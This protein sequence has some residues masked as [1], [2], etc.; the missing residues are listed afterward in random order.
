MRRQLLT[1]AAIVCVGIFGFAVSRIARSQPVNV[2]NPQE[3]VKAIRRGGLREVAKVKG[4]YISTVRSSGWI[5][6]DVDSLTKNSSAVIV[7]ESGASASELSSNGE[8]ITTQYQVKIREV[9][10]GDVIE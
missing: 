8:S 9:L 3:E 2:P 5:K 1:I 10:K 7:G 6:E 4:H